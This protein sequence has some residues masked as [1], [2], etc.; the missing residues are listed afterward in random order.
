MMD[1]NM[2]DVMDDVDRELAKELR[3][4]DNG[5]RDVGEEEEKALEGERRKQD[6]TM[7]RLPARA[8]PRFREHARDRSPTIRAMGVREEEEP[9]GRREGESWKE[10]MRR[11]RKEKKVRT[12]QR[13]REDVERI[14]RKEVT[15]EEVFLERMQRSVAGAEKRVADE[16]KRAER[17][18]KRKAV[19]VERKREMR[20]A[21][22]MK[23]R[24][25]ARGGRPTGGG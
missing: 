22:A 4:A 20:V 16:A 17:R 24:E 12:K 8:V 10:M 6:D 11:Q 9:K 18:M 1:V 15:A 19:W 5:G 23:K 13:R 21:A 3:R 7:K 14:R 2:A 25:L